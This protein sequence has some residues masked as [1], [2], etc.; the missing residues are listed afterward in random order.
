MFLAVGAEGLGATD[1][2]SDAAAT[3]AF[4]YIAYPDT[5]AIPPAGQPRDLAVPLGEGLASSDACAAA[6]GAYANASVSPVSGWAR[7]Q[8][9]A[10]GLDGAC[11]GWLDS[12]GPSSAWRPE[13]WPAAPGVAS[14]RMAYNGSCADARDCSL[15]GVCDA[16]QCRCD[17][18]WQ[19]PQCATLA[20]TPAPAWDSSSNGGSAAGPDRGGRNGLR[21]VDAGGVNVSTWGGSVLAFGGAWH[22]WASEM[23]HH[24]GLSSW[25]SN[26][27]ILHAVAAAPEGPY[28]VA[29]V[30]VDVFAHEPTVL[31]APSDTSGS[32][33]P[34]DLIVMF[35][36]GSLEP[37]PR[38]LCNC[39]DGSTGVDECA[40]VD[41]PNLHEPTLMV[42]ATS[43]F[44]PWSQPAVVLDPSPP[45]DTNLAPVIFRNG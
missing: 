9:F 12:G 15:N 41:D 33:D 31:R 1:R 39:S 32:D 26:S 36:T 19:G 4:A 23:V 38:P 11:T 16:G 40:T 35:Y 7:C 8:S 25:R 30:A 24:C 43:P 10:L 18:A 44:G 29:G 17:A 27:R 14:G 21:I 6:C 3:T 28:S 37:Y 45:L 34:D 13:D 22:L 5:D 42:F 20:L 2:R